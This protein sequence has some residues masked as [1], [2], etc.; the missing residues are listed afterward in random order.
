MLFTLKCVRYVHCISSIALHFS[1]FLY[2]FFF[3]FSFLLV[4]HSTAFILCMF[5]I[6]CIHC[7]NGNMKYFVDVT[8]MEMLK[9]TAIFHDVVG[10][11]GKSTNT[12]L[13]EHFCHLHFSEI[14]SSSGAL[15]QHTTSRKDAERGKIHFICC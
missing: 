2:F 4:H 10:K 7:I 12:A 13:H 11:I 14:H 6:A 1:G 15:A 9:C 3:N 8:A 5:L